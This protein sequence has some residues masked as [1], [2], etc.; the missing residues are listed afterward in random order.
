MENELRNIWQE[1]E[2]TFFKVAVQAVNWKN[3]LG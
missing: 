1:E 3:I 2:K